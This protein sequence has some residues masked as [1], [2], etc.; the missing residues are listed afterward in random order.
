MNTEER[1]RHFVSAPVL[2][3]SEFIIA[4]LAIMQAGRFA[5]NPAYAG[6]AVS[7]DE[8]FS[9]VASSSGRGPADRPYDLIYVIDSSEESLYIYWIENANTPATSRLQ[10]RGG[11]FLP[12]LFEAGRGG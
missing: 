7:T 6:M 1:Q 8:G 4:A 11:A 2:W 3:A 12:R 10:L 9:L 5:P